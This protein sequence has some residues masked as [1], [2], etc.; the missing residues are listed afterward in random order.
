MAG[1]PESSSPIPITLL[2][3]FL[4]SGKTTLL[5]R[6][7]RQPAMA[8]ALVIINEFGEIGL[9][10]RLFTAS[11]EN[12]Q[13]ELSNGCLCCAVRGDLVKTLS[14]APWRFARQGQRQFDRVVIESSG[15]ADPAP[16]LHTLAR[17]PR[18]M[19]RYR[20]DGVVT[21]VDAVN[22]A[23]TLERFDEARRQVTL[24]DLLLVTKREMSDPA[25]RS[26]LE[27]RLDSLNPAA[28]RLTIEHGELDAERL[29]GI[30]APR[31][32]ASLAEAFVW[33]NA[34][35]NDALAPLHSA[36]PAA[37]HDPGVESF[38]I[39]FDRPIPPARLEEWL[40]LSQTLMGERMLRFKGLLDLEG[41]T[42]PTV[43]HGVQH[44]IH[45][46]VELDAWPDDE[47]GSRLVFIT[48]DLPREELTRSL[49]DF[50]VG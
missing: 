14:D 26:R 43:I 35:A 13:V 44:L 24:A 19:R 23:S 31:E 28:P 27:A 46:P 1:E 11:Q 15:L 34:A 50:L 17:H 32:G 2:S 5:N 41:R 42:R 30:G 40:E 16:V 22:G 38:S 18:L 12:V 4:G 7:V 21:T 9:D 29:L 33:I 20:L 6:L 25:S 39:T 10:H 45:P 47:R 36:A 3:G 48:K 49:R 37:K 8:R